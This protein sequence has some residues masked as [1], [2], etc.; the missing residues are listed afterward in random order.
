[1]DYIAIDF[2]TANSR[3]T[4]VC[5]IG[6]VGV[7]NNKI[8]FEEYHL[9]NPEEEFNESNVM[10]HNITKDDVLDKD[11]FAVV[12]KKIEKHFEN[13]IIF[14]HNAEFDVGV[15]KAVIE[16]YQLKQPNIKFGC[17]LKIACK[18]WSKEVLINHKLNTISQYLEIDH[19]HHHA[20]SDAKICVEIINRGQ[21]IMNVS[22]VNEL[23]D[24]LG[25]RYGLYNKDR[26]FLSLNK[27]KRNPKQKIIDNE[28]LNDKVI[29]YAGKP[30]SLSKK[31]LEDKLLNNGVYLEK[32]I[33]RS[34]DYF[35]I[36]G[37][38]PKLKISLVETLIQK[39][40]PIKIISEEEI[41][42]MIK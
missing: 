27:Y 26:F 7:V 6:I 10:I 42:K 3:L 1:M 32:N 21:K 18:L 35:L 17:T 4:S 41:I 14:A 11:N 30:S 20:L 23:Y 28:L 40:V 34:L 29:Y 5:S 16:K 9:I 38:C 12:W 39:G 25:L 24:A 19:H 37:N 13:T 8:V 22:D 2:E 15:L 33:N 36:L 31:E